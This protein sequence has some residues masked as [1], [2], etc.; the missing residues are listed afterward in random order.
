[1]CDPD[2]DDDGLLDGTEDADG[3]GIVDPLETDPADFDTD[4]DGLSDGLESGLTAPEGGDTDP[5]VFTADADPNSTTDPLVVDTDGGT[6]SDGIEDTNQNGAVD[7]DERDPNDPTDDLYLDSD[8]DGFYDVAGGGTDCD[9]TD[10]TIFP[11]APEIPDDGIDQDCDGVDAAE[12]FADDDLDTFGGPTTVVNLAGNCT[13]AGFAAT[14]TDCDDNDPNAYPGAPE[15]VD[16]GIDE[17]CSGADEI[18]CFVDGDG[19]TFGAPGTSITDPLGLCTGTGLSPND[20]DCNDSDSAI[21]PNAVDIPDDTIDQDCSGT[22]TVT[23]F[24]DADLDTFGS[25]TTALD[26]LGV[27]GPG[28]STLN[29]DCD[30]AVATTFPGAPEACNAV[31]DDCDGTRDPNGTCAG[32]TRGDFNGQ[33]YALCTG[34]DQPWTSAE[35]WCSSRGYYLS[36]IND[37]LENGYLWAA[38]LIDANN[39][40][41]FGYNDIATEGTFVWSAAN[42]SGYTAWH[43][44]EP[45]NAG[46]NEDCVQL[47]RY[48][49]PTWN[50]EPCNRSFNYIC[51]AD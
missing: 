24:L 15:I 19:D 36:T 23:C 27:C 2:T 8:N 44:G 20:L 38:T 22:D 37:L 30:D 41:W 39:K 29:T 5:A 18:T 49:I 35:T 10:P 6:V 26:P 16:N 9:D 13:D 33:L 25:T 21:N 47:R 50:D 40:W 4:G 1:M 42:G 7:P 12:C 51:E 3:N 11:G 34:N 28:F 43:T 17:D 48:G 46:G 32:C 14:N 45:N 31:D